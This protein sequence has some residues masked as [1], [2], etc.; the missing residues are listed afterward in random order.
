VWVTPGVT[1]GNPYGRLALGASTGRSEVERLAKWKAADFEDE[2]W[3][4]VATQYKY[5]EIWAST[6]YVDD[7]NDDSLLACTG[8]TKRNVDE[9]YAIIFEDSETRRFL[10]MR[11]GFRWG[12]P[13]CAR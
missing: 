10:D 4:R 13:A 7:R 12:G 9:T 2:N 11:K 5:E 8:C 1:I 3:V 6:K